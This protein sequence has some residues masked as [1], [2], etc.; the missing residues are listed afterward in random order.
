M[1][2]EEV[3]SKKIQ[4]SKS[5]FGHTF[6]IHGDDLLNITSIEEAQSRLALFKDFEGTTPRLDSDTLVLF[7]INDSGRI[8]LCSP[9]KTN[10][11]RGYGFSQG[12][13][14]GGGSRE[15]LI[16]PGTKDQL[17]IYNIQLIPLSNMGK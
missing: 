5:V 11:P 10:P 3:G 13:I 16:N 17:G 7:K 4:L 14:T 1:V 2:I 6:L 8:G 9:I 15:W 12:G